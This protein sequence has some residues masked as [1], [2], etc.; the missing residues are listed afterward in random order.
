[1]AYENQIKCILCG[2]SIPQMPEDAN[3]D[4]LICD[5]CYEECYDETYE[6]GPADNSSV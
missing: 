6:N 3:N 4:E 1:M 5:G 2:K